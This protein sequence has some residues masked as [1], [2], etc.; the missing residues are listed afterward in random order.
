VFETFAKTNEEE[1]EAPEEP[2]ASSANAKVPARAPRKAAQTARFASSMSRLAREG[3][4]ERER[5]MKLL[6]IAFDLEMFFFPVLANFG[7][8][9]KKKRKERRKKTSQISRTRANYRKREREI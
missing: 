9:K 5:D 3:G 2:D 4:R 7:V 1:E 6:S 8:S